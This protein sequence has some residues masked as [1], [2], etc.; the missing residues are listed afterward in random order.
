MYCSLKISQP[1]IKYTLPTINNIT[2]IEYSPKNYGRW[3]V[4]KHRLS[5]DHIKIHGIINII[6]RSPTSIPILKSVAALINLRSAL[7]C[8]SLNRIRTHWV[9]AGNQCSS[10]RTSR[11]KEIEFNLQ[12]AQQHSQQQQ[13]LAP[14]IILLNLS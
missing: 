13:H 11:I 6:T 5:H 14:I 2:R 3:R 7:T 9:R 4:R 12:N 1:H 10:R 8:G